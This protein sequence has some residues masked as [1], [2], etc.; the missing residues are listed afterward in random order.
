VPHKAGVGG[1]I[2]GIPVGYDVVIRGLLP[3]TD[4]RG[5]ESDTEIP[6]DYVF[7]SKTIS[8]AKPGTLA[9][10]DGSIKGGEVN[11]ASPARLTLK[12]TRRT[13]T[14]TVTK[15]WFAD[16]A[17][18]TG[19]A[20]NALGVDK[21]YFN[22]YRKVDDSWTL[23]N[24]QGTPYAIEKSQ[25]WTWT[26]EPLPLGQYMVA[27]CAAD[28]ETQSVGATYSP[29]T[30]KLAEG[31]ATGSISIENPLT[32]YEV[33]K[34]WS[35]SDKA[36]SDYVVMAQLKRKTADASDSAY[37]N[38]GTP[39]VLDKA[40]WTYTWPNLSQYD[41]QTGRQYVYIAEESAVYAGRSS[42]ADLKDEFLIQ[43]DR[44]AQGKTIISNTQYHICIRKV[45]DKGSP[46]A[47]AWFR[48]LKG[49]EC[50]DVDGH[51]DEGN[52]IVEG[53][54]A[55]RVIHNLGPGEYALKE[56]KTPTGYI[57]TVGDIEFEIKDDGSVSYEPSIADAVIVYDA[58]THTFTITVTNEP[59]ASLPATG[60]PG[61]TLYYAAGA[62]LLLLAIATLIFRKK[63]DGE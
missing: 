45:D 8:N 25:G 12:N 22:L 54:G 39:V 53:D 23:V 49:M 56:V 30:I 29:S 51:D 63:A 18:I 35:D 60:G 11:E 14:L 2:Q 15:A 50:V 9:D 34:R 42:D 61:T 41:Y 33:E 40:S 28:G 21:I 44:T 48:L 31:R 55:E 52:F 4:F 32:S 19:D 27:E 59:G 57:K 62:A 7:T 1:S 24:P 17:A 10:A 13:V 20:L 47:G 46:L 26:S 3:G 37:E 58:D 43:Y 36:A 5:C 38:Y 6:V 16:G